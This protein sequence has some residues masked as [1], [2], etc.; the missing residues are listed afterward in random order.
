MIVKDVV[1]LENNKKIKL[2]NRNKKE[3]SINK[4][5]KMLNLIIMRKKFNLK[6]MSWSNNN[7]RNIRRKVIK[8]AIISN[9]IRIRSRC[10]NKK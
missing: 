2:D 10:K 6:K 1:I 4:I 8:K 5:I 7:N 9:I 3:V